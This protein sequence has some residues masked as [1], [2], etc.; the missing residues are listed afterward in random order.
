MDRLAADADR[1]SDVLL[2]NFGQAIAMPCGTSRGCGCCGA[3]ELSLLLT[4][5]SR[6]RGGGVR[7]LRR[8]RKPPLLQLSLLPLLL[9]PVASTQHFEE[10][11]EA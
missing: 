3:Q 6:G 9:A 11:A 8:L 1:V 5:L 7:S 4:L 10:R 2:D